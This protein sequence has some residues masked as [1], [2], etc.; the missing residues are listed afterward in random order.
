MSE[1]LSVALVRCSAASAFAFTSN[2]A[3]GDTVTI[4]DKVYTFAADAST[5]A[6]LVDVGTDLDES[7]TDLV[8]AINANGVGDGTDY[9][10]G[11][12]VNPYVVA[13]ADLVNDE[14]DLVARVPGVMGSAIALAAT[15]PG[16]NDI[17]AGGSSL[18]AVSGATKGSGSE[19]AFMLAID[20]DGLQPNAAI[21][22]V[23]DQYRNESS[24]QA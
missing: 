11:T 4:G 2:V 10:T 23:I 24:A 19:R 8:A 3:A 9:G 17:T 21:L 20:T 14:I 7:I 22:S 1:A 16:A 18:G 13:T 15:S 6:Y 12:A 5:A